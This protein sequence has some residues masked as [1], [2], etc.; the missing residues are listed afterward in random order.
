VEVVEEEEEEEDYNDSESEAI[1][2][3]EEEEENSPSESESEE[4]E[5]EDISMEEE[6]PL[7]DDTTKKFRDYYM[8]KITQAF[9]S[10]LDQ[11]RQVKKK[12]NDR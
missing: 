2:Q 5:K 9:G 6:K 12:R 1:K 10:D 7:I 11:I 3:E 8:S 4:E